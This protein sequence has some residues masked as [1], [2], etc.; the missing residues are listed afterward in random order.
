MVGPSRKSASNRGLIHVPMSLSLVVVVLAA[1]GIWNF[2][3]AWEGLARTQLRLDRCVGMATQQLRT[4]LRRLDSLNGEIKMLR[5]ALIA[6]AFG[7]PEARVALELKLK[8]TAL[9]QDAELR[10]WETAR[11]RWALGRGCREPADQ[12]RPLPGIPLRRP[13][14]DLWGPQPLVRDV[15]CAPE[16]RVEA[17]N[18]PRTSAGQVKGVDHEISWTT[19][20]MRPNFRPGGH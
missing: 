1:T 4:H 3:R 10:I 19:A 8:A 11:V 12:A 6:G 17:R 2:R 18:G 15:G 13:P 5:A 14:P 9:A 20:T 7:G 16:L